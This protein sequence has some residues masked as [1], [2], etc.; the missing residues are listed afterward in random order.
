MVVEGNWDYE[1]AGSNSQFCFMWL[2][3]FLWQSSLATKICLEPHST[4]W[5][6]CTIR[7]FYCFFVLEERSIASYEIDGFI[8]FRYSFMLFWFVLFYLFSVFS[9]GMVFVLQKS[10][11]GSSKFSVVLFEKIN[12][13][14]Y[15]WIN[16]FW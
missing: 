5:T 10:W 13:G 11:H 15:V 4:F 6:F 16:Y 7:I 1:V 9:H 3:I 14:N 8:H 12:H 2:E